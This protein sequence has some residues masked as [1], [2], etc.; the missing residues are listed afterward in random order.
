MVVKV[1]VSFFK[2][3]CHPGRLL[4]DLEYFIHKE[5]IPFFDGEIGRFKSTVLRFFGWLMLLNSK[6]CFVVG[7]FSKV[8]HEGKAQKSSCL[9]LKV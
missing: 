4:D 1:E 8:I 7:S 2:N 3:I 9:V 6:T 5:N